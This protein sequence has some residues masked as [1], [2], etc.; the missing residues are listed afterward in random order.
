MEINQELK[1]TLDNLKKS[2]AGLVAA[3]K[4]KAKDAV[5]QKFRDENFLLKNWDKVTFGTENS[6]VAERKTEQYV[7]HVSIDSVFT[8]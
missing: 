2:E 8:Y 4:E 7:A 1:Q 6:K 3:A 5:V